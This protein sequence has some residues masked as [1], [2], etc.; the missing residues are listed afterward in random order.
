MAKLLQI[1]VKTTTK[2]DVAYNEVR[3][4]VG[5]LARQYVS[6]GILEPGRAYPNSDVT[7]GE[8]ALWQE[9]GTKPKG[10]RPGIPARSFLRTPFDKGVN[11]IAALKTRLLGQIFEGKLTVS[12]GLA[13]LGADAVR[14]I[15]TTIKKR[16]E[17]PLR[18]YT[19]AKRREQRITGTIPLLA[20]RFLFDSIHF[21]VRTGNKD[22]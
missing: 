6:I 10:S 2:G 11:A 14:R 21:A 13:R 19:L 15:Q 7:V 12:D 1:K 18:P 16:I 3:R 20:T 4:Q 9:F 22:R 17:P 8:V 5:E